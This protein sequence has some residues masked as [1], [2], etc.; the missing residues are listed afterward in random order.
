MALL[1]TS[2][3]NRTVYHNSKKHYEITYSC[4]ARTN[5]IVY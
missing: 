5:G 1:Q 3:F 2:W 4:I